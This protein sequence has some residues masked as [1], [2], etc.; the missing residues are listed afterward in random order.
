MKVDDIISIRWPGRKIHG[1]LARVVSIVEASGA[2]P[3]GFM[4]E[5]LEE[6]GQYRSRSD[7]AMPTLLLEETFIEAKE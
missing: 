6:R 1:C 7:G 2:K 5:L 4:V 3:G